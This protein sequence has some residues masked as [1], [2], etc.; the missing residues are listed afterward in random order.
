L[1]CFLDL[2]PDAVR[3]LKETLPSFGVHVVAVAWST[4]LALLA[5]VMAGRQTRNDKGRIISLFACRVIEELAW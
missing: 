5:P 2:L 4:R 1:L 3:N